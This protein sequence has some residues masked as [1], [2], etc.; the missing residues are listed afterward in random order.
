MTQLVQPNAVARRAGSLRLSLLGDW[1]LERDGTPISLL[2]RERQLIA[3]LALHGSRQRSYVAGLFWPEVDEA[4]ARA[5]LRQVLAGIRRQVPEAVV[6]V[7]DSLSL[8]P[9]IR[10]D[11]DKVRDWCRRVHASGSS[12][13]ARDA[14]E[15][16]QVLGGPE[17][18][19]GEFDDWVLVERERIQRNR[20]LALEML[21]RRLSDLNEVPYAVAACEYAADLEPL[22][23][24]PVRMLV[25]IHLKHG[26]RVDAQ[27]AY[28]SFKRRLRA[29]LD[30][31]P[32]P[33]LTALLQA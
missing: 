4:R 29:Y 30:A 1:R 5:S 19:I 8:A 20:L 32:S 14:V 28:E 3:L 26:N 33:E 15:A 22:R 27:H 2:H 23:E 21:S 24:G 9:G 31:D 11:V 7:G 18:L 12:L 25:H 17:L 10:T 6:V 16:L 13:R